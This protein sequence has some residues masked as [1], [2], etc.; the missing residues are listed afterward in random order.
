MSANE[1]ATEQRTEEPL[2]V[3]VA[4]NDPNIAELVHAI[5]SLYEEARGYGLEGPVRRLVTAM[6]AS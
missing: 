6:G 2:R 4:D 3:L 1:I 5:S